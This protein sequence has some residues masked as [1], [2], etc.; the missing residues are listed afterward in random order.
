MHLQDMILQLSLYSDMFRHDNAIFREYTSSSVIHFTLIRF[1]FG[2]YSLK[3]A[4]L[5]HNTILYFE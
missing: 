5:R 3:M 1:R 2:M 4:L